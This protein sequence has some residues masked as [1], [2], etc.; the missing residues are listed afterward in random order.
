MLTIKNE[1]KTVLTGFFDKKDTCNCILCNYE[2]NKIYNK[3]KLVS[4]KLDCKE[5]LKGSFERIHI[6][7]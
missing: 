3:R 2:I 4:N 5:V 7:N 6:I 1:Y